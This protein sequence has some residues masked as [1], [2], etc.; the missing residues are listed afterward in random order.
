[1]QFQWASKDKKMGR[2]PNSSYSLMCT[3]SLG[4]ALNCV[5]VCTIP[6]K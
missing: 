6:E 1:M 3:F 5:T 4:E 2:I